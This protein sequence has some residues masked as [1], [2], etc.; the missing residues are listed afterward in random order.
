MICSAVSNCS[1]RE[2]WLTS[3]VWIS[4]DAL[5]LSC[6]TRSIASCS[7][8]AVSVFGG[9]GEADMAVADLHEGQLVAGWCRRPA[10]RRRAA[11]SA[12]RRR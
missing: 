4:S 3:P 6:V 10:R 5:P 2:S 11:P 7:V 12:A 8:P 1:A 9:V